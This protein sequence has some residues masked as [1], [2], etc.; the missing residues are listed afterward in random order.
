MSLAIHIQ[1]LTFEY[2]KNIPILKNIE[3]KVEKGEVF[4]LLGAQ[5]SG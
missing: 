2:E 3:L 1:D 5:R 4:G